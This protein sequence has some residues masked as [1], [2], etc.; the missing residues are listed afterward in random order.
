[1]VDA[2]RLHDPKVARRRLR[3]HAVGDTKLANAN[4]ADADADCN[5]RLDFEEFMAM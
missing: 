3:F 4:F 2:S 5:E 1:M